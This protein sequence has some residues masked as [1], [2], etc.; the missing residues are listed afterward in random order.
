MNPNALR[1]I[2]ETLHNMA[3]EAENGFPADP[4]E[5][6]VAARKLEAQAEMMEMEA[7]Q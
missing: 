6:R 1:K 3:C 7:A 2:A 4:F 5:L